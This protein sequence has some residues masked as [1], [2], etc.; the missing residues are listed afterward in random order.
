MNLALP[1]NQ[2]RQVIQPTYAWS[3]L[4]S[5]LPHGSSSLMDVFKVR[6]T[7]RISVQNGR[8]LA[9]TEALRIEVTTLGGQQAV[10]E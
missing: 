9:G 4:A 5:L 10:R 7:F 1:Y 6:D 3:M 8:A 2:Q